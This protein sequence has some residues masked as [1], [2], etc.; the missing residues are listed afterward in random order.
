MYC[1]FL[2]TDSCCLGT[3]YLKMLMCQLLTTALP[4]SLCG[5]DVTCL[6][7]PEQLGLVLKLSV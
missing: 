2:F 4:Y 3:L 7:Q 5:C 6:I 1:L